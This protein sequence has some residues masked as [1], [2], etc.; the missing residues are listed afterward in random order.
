MLDVSQTGLQGIAVSVPRVIERPAIDYVA[1]AVFG[2]MQRLP[3]FAPP[4]IAELSEVMKR[5]GIPG[6]MPAFFRYRRFGA[7]GSVELEVGTTVTRPVPA[8]DGMVSGQLPAGRY[9]T[10]TLFGPYDRLYD[11]FL[12]LHGWMEGRGLQASATNGAEGSHPECQM[13][14]YRVGPVQTENPMRFETDLMLKL[15]D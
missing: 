10:A 6:G 8:I 14:I 1:I 4:K 2:P 13:E 15:S 5:S 12:M 3:E 11:S 7:D 9:A